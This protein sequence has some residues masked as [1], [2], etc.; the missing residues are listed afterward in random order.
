MLR[1]RYQL[2]YKLKKEYNLSIFTPIDIYDHAH[3]DLNIKENYLNNSRKISIFNIIKFYSSLRKLYQN[4]YKYTFCYGVGVCLL[5]GLYFRIFGNQNSRVVFFF[6]GLGAIFLRKRYR[7]FRYILIRFLMVQIPDKIVVLNEDDKKY[8]YENSN[9]EN[10]IDKII[11]MK[12]EGVPIDLCLNSNK[13][14]NIISRLVFVGRPVLDKGCIEFSNLIT[15]LRKNNV[16]LPVTVYGFDKENEGELNEI[17]FDKLHSLGVLF[18]GHV[19]NLESHLKS[20]D[21][22]LIISEREGANRVLLECLHLGLLFIASNVPG[23]KNFVPNS[24]KAKLL[25]DFDNPSQVIKKIISILKHSPAENRRCKAFMKSDIKYAS[26]EDIFK[27][28]KIHLLN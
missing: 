28:Y 14:N 6:T 20:S 11:V 15:Q 16:N 22:I 5:L 18:K 26:N 8:L 9:N 3:L 19:S 17:Y 2:F 24:L 7:F 13:H 21:L 25:T 27:F 10:L 1:F 23:I 4:N 12:G